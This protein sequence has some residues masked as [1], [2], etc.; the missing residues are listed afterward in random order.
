MCVIPDPVPAL[1]PASAV[2]AG[3]AAASHV[4]KSTTRFQAAP[5]NKDA[6]MAGVRHPSAA[7]SAPLRCKD[8]ASGNKCVLES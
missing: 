4:L 1:L 3:I 6:G 5:Q 7:I 2:A 8:R